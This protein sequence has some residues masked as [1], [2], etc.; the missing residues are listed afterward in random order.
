MPYSFCETA[1]AGPRSKWHIRQLTE[2]GQKFGGG[3]DTPS[4]CGRDVAWDLEVRLTLHHLQNNACPKCA[5]RYWG[6][7]GDRVRLTKL[8]DSYPGVPVGM[9]GIVLEVDHVAT[10]HVRWDNGVEH[11]LCPDVDE[12]EVI[13]HNPVHEDHQ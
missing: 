8:E 4:L 2:V 13:E 5:E 12:W 10:R 9:E 7:E 6:V 3:A 11:G 1:T